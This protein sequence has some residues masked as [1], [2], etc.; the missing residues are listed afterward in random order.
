[1]SAEEVLMLYE[2]YTVDYQEKWEMLR[3]VNYHIVASQSSK[4]IK[5][6]D[7]MSFPWD[8]KSINKKG[9]EKDTKAE[10]NRIKKKFKIK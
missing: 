3:L 1:M 5:I 8:K 6:T 4:P 2:A 9:N 10:I 7:I